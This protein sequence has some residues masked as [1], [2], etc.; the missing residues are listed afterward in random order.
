MRRAEVPEIQSARDEWSAHAHSTTFRTLKVSR[1]R[2]RSVRIE[3]ID[4]A[5][6][7]AIEADGDVRGRTPVELRVVP[8]VLRV[9]C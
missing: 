5:D 4:A 7:L 6:S 9:V 8:R 3:T 2:G 1:A